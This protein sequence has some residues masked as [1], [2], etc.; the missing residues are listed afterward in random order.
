MGFYSFDVVETCFENLTKIK[1]II[2]NSWFNHCEH[3]GWSLNYQAWA[4]CVHVPNNLVSWKSIV[5]GVKHVLNAIL[6]RTSIK[7]N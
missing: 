5:R 4:W 6:K 7:I 3:Y 1:L 2:A